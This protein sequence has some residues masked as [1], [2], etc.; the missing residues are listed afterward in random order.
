M[1]YW[2]CTTCGTQFAQSQLAP[3]KCPIC[4]VTNV[5]M[6]DIRG[7]SGPR[8]P[9]CRKTTFITKKKFPTNFSRKFEFCS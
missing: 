9:Q 7:S 3:E 4:T 2:I 6:S 1:E 8:S 5:S